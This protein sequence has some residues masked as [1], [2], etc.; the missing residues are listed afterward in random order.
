[1][2]P[3]RPDKQRSRGD[4]AACD[5]C[6]ERKRELDAEHL[7]TRQQVMADALMT[8]S[9]LGEAAPVGDDGNAKPCDL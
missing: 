6:K 7:L 8:R 1:V 9:I 5:Y 2:A 4:R 3:P